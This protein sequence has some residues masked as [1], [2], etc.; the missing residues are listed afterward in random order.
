MSDSSISDIS[1]KSKH[2]WI[3]QAG[4]VLIILGFLWLVGVESGQATLVFEW[5]DRSRTFQGDVTD[6]MTVLDALNVS[7]LAGNIEFQFNL[8]DRNNTQLLRLDGYQN[9]RETLEVLVNDQSIQVEQLNQ[10]Y[11]HPKDT[12]RVRIGQ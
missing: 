3:W 9:S 8:D 10:V 11:I 12:I 5:P 2:P 7:A 4:A 6:G 1:S